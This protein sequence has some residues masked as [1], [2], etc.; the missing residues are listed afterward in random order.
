MVKVELATV[1]EEL[2]SLKIEFNKPKLKST[3]KKKKM[4]R[5]LHS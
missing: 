3:Q 1:Q 2:Q 4:M 5:L